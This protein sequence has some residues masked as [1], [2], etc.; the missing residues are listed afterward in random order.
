MANTH[1]ACTSTTT[2][3]RFG[4][5]FVGTNVFVNAAYKTELISRGKPWR[6]VDDVELATAF[7]VSRYNRERL[8]QAL[9]DQ[10]PAEFETALTTASQP[11][12]QPTPVLATT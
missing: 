11:A 10:T 4:I 8:H 6:S 1:R 7:W 5:R 12:S 9:G 2:A 3:V